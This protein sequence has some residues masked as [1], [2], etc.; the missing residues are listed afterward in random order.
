MSEL[1]LLFIQL[2]GINTKR[3]K[4]GTDKDTKVLGMFFVNFLCINFVTFLV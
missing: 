2:Y 4:F 1:L 3:T